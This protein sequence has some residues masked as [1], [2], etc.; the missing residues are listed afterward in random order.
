[1]MNDIIKD[2]EELIKSEKDFWEKFKSQCVTSAEPRDWSN[3]GKEV[4]NV[5]IAEVAKLSN[6]Y[7]ELLN[8]VISK[9]ILEQKL[10]IDDLI[11]SSMKH[12]I[13]LYVAVAI[14]IKQNKDAGEKELLIKNEDEILELNSKYWN[15]INQEIKKSY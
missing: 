12:L 14:L 5:M 6:R 1:M 13:K 3:P 2:F 7:K 9:L 8:S 10:Q 4:I 11:C 15:E